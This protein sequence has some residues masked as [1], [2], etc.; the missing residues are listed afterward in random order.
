MTNMELAIAVPYEEL[1]KEQL[2]VAIHDCLNLLMWRGTQIGLKGDEAVSAATSNG[3]LAWLHDTLCP[4][5][6]PT[7][8]SPE[9][10][11]RVLMDNATARIKA[12]EAQIDALREAV[13]DF[14]PCELCNKP[15]AGLNGP[16]FPKRP[17]VYHRASYAGN[18]YPGHER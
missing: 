13:G 10:S 3:V 11:L 8:Q 18:P 9:K 1:T 15:K 5:G 4:E 14:Y 12:L 6:D 7:V 16:R 2:G 17:V